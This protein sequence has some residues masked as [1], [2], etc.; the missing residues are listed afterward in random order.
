MTEPQR[1]FY[2]RRGSPVADV[3]TI[4]HLPYTAWHL[5]YVVI[6]A[7]LSP[8]VDWLRLAGTLV[9]FAAGLGVAAH[10]L[11][12][13]HDRPLATSLSD[14]T[15]W[16]LGMG[17]LAVAVGVA[18]AGAVVISPWVLAWAAGGVLLT[19]A[20]S[21]EWSDLIHSDLGFGFAW[22]AFP[23]MVGYW[24]QTEAISVQALVAAALATAFSLVQ[25]SLSS[26]AKKIRR[27]PDPAPDSDESQVLLATW[28]KPLRILSVAMPLLALTLLL[29][30]M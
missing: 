29:T 10:A 21:L 26:A 9:A 17:G 16:A 3:I 1:A 15:L 2:A 20:Y 14:R 25:R 27:R 30:H 12:E 8:Q 7:A 18:V 11:D 22:G 13:V 6:G 28:E 23:L 4:L 19:F 24:A 5:S